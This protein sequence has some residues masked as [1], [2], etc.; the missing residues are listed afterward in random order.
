MLHSACRR[1]LSTRG[2]YAS[3]AF[4]AFQVGRIQTPT[5][6]AFATQAEQ[7]ASPLVGVRKKL[8]EF[9]MSTGR[10]ANALFE[11][12]DLDENGSID[13]NELKLFMKEVLKTSEGEEV[14]PKEIMPYAWKSLE[15][16]AAA[17]ESYDIKHFKN[18]LVAATKLSADMKNSRLLDYLNHHP[19]TGDQYSSGVEGEDHFTWNIETMS[20]SLRRMQ[21]AVRGEVVMRADQLQAQG[22]NVLYTNIGNPHQV[23]QSPITYYRQ[24]LALCDLPAEQGVD[25]PKVLEMFPKDVVER[26]REYRECI[27]PSG[28]GAYTHSQG[29]L[30]FRKHVADFI[31]ARDNYPSYPGNIFLT[32]GASS[33]IAMCLQGLLASNNCAVMIPIPQYPIYSALITKLNGRQVGYALDE[34]LNWAVSREELDNKLEE[35]KSQGLDVRALA[36]INPGNPSGNVMTHADIQVITE[37][38]AEH[39]IVLLADEVYQSNVYAEG[40]EFVSAKKVALDCNLRHLQLISFHSTSK[41]LIGECGRRGGYMELRHIDPYVQSQLYKLAS[42]DL[43]SGV[44][45]QIM[46]SLMVRPPASGDESYD[47]FQEE[48][49]RI[50]DGLKDRSQKLVDGLNKIPGITCVPAEGA[51]Y[52]F[53]RVEIPQK[54]IEKA[55]DLGTTPDNLYALSLLEETGICVVPASGFG[56]AKGRVGFR[57]TFLH[58]DTLSAIDLFAKHHESFTKEYS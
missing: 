51:M 1:L 7:A 55:K 25:H 31:Q 20:Q 15:Q 23:G 36:M 14:D 45:G 22:R 42:S 43:C 8:W 46:T 48:N 21:Y 28:T 39:G 29:I 57:T 49:Q 2:H 6:A 41:G 16:R 11:A 38:C 58:P 34:S 5:C 33:A 13:P 17:G 54:A 32:N 19:N 53:P 26:A 50:F 35:A 4:S 37:F 30:G 27:G 10:G 9:Y 44:M 3:R 52:A 47:L 12:I 24:V 56:Q 40:A 18:W